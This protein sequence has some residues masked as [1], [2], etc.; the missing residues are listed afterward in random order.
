MA[1]RK[2][3]EI[4]PT[5]QYCDE[6]LIPSFMNR[7]RTRVLTPEICRPKDEGDCIYY[8]MQR[9]MRTEDNYALLFANH[10]AKEK[11]VALKVMYVLPPPMKSSATDEDD[12]PPKVCEMK[13]TERYGS[14][15]LG[16]LKI[17]E[18]NLHEKNVN[19][20]VLMPDDDGSV[21]E[22]VSKHLI[23][24]NAAATI[25]DMSPLRQ[26]RQWMEVQTA[27]RLSSVNI[28]L[29][30]CDAHNVVPVWYASPKR[31]V[32]ARTLRPK[33]NKVLQDFMRHFPTF[34]GNGEMQV[35]TDIDW[36]KC[37]QHLDMDQDVKSVAHFQ[38]G[39]EHAMNRFQDFI[40]SQTEGLKNFD[41]L[42][43]DPNFKNVC[44]NL[45]Y[46]LSPG[47]LQFCFQP[48]C[49]DKCSFLSKPLGE[50]WTCFLSTTCT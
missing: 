20:E 34:E 24:N 29:F 21:G 1:S 45:R 30:Q 40:S 23:D 18:Q 22:T 31:E 33:I 19:F 10:L 42:R 25:V 6:D 5:V 26:F 16:G 36:S 2:K 28:P 47:L 27:P 9:D 4:E 7:E 43:N 15:L 13:M 17:V 12:L 14:F 8:W 32:G 39:K 41:T 37:E 11:N 46:V 3:K 49:I 35:L 50:L 44:S 38:P 48:L